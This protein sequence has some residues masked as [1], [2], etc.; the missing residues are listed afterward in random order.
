MKNYKKK[1]FNDVVPS[2]FRSSKDAGKKKSK[3]IF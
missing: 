3:W 2:L 1:K